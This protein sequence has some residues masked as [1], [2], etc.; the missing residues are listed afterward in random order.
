MIVVTGATGQVGSRLVTLLAARGHRVRA[1]A[2]P[3]AGA[4]VP[5][6]EL[7]ETVEADF[8]DRDALKR[9]ADGADR[10]FMLAPPSPSQPR[11]QQNILDAAGGAEL[12]VKLSAFD[13]GPDSRLT[14]GRWHHEGEQ[15]LR[16]SG[17]PHVILRPQYFVQNLL[18]DEAALR[19][20]VLRTFIPPGRQIGMVDAQDVAA[21]AAAVLLAPPAGNPVLVP[22]GPRAVSTAE[23][24]HALSAALGV[25]VRETYLA[26]TSAMTALLAAGRP[27]WHAEDT[28]EICQTGS[29]L[30]TGAVEV[31]VGRPARD[32]VDVINE[33]FRP[34][35][36]R[37]RSGNR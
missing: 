31:A 16:E 26:P 12:V 30:V 22:T 23:V 2:E 13:S 9:S 19:S 8:G 29:P 1:V 18:H 4:A 20:G 6:G 36:L 33:R 25:T 11:W 21:V 37:Q 17:M 24:A 32:I 15:A 14:M 7:V 35:N 27:V 34:A 3:G 5:F 10:F 28:I